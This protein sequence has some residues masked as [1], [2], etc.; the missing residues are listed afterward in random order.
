MGISRTREFGALANQFFTRP[1]ET[2]ASQ[3]Q[4][5]SSISDDAKIL[6]TVIPQEFAKNITP[7]LLGELNKISNKSGSSV[8]FLGRE[9]RNQDAAT[10]N[11]LL[12]KFGELD[13]TFKQVEAVGGG[14]TFRQKDLADLFL[15]ALITARSS[16]GVETKATPQQLTDAARNRNITTFTGLTR[17]GAAPLGAFSGLSRPQFG[18]A[19]AQR[20]QE[21]KD[22]AFLEALNTLKEA[23]ITGSGRDLPTDLKNLEAEA[24]RRL[25]K[26]GVVTALESIITGLFNRTSSSLGLTGAE[27]LRS[28]SGVVGSARNLISAGNLPPEVS[29]QLSAL[30]T[31]YTEKVAA[32]PKINT[33]T[34]AFA[35][36]QSLGTEV[37][38]NSTIVKGGQEIAFIR[39]LEIA[40]TKMS[41]EVK[42]LSQ[43]IESL[44]ATV[45]SL[46]RE[47][48]IILNVPEQIRANLS[49]EDRMVL[50]SILTKATKMETNMGILSGKPVP[51][52]VGSKSF[53]STTK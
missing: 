41:D 52:I 10:L 46:D 45:S 37:S 5:E 50:E 7:E 40:A 33:V 23:G 19:P 34:Q 42:T 28:E 35:P 32:L 30:L 24:Q 27:G 12:A 11:A 38:A 48:R 17:E 15:K 29:A 3:A 47:V 18:T 49:D 36:G 39:P 43:N 16:T 13:S 4:R 6:A 51:P 14:E 53:T 21:I 44:S 9:E 25:G 2:S 22:R 1:I 26:E 8:G 31:I 20:T